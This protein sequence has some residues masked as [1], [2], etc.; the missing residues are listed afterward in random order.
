[1]KAESEFSRREAMRIA[2][3][4]STLMLVKGCV[5]FRGTDDELEQVFADLDDTL[6]LLADDPGQEARLLEIAAQIAAVS[7]NLCADHDD[8]LQRFDRDSRQFETSNA[9]LQSLVDEFSSN[10][11]LNGRLLLELQEAL[12]AELSPEEWQQVTE[13]LNRKSEILQRPTIGAA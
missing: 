8:F 12:R 4:V 9:A 1:M 10:R 7:R 3:A 5:S 13:L 2:L 11:T 6:Q